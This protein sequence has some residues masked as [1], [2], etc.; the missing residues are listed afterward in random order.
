MKV[1]T[2]KREIFGVHF[3]ALLFLGKWYGVATF[4]YTKKKEKWGIT[5]LIHDCINLDYEWNSLLRKSFF[6]NI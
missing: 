2:Q 4:F 5:I 6:K 1:A 3:R